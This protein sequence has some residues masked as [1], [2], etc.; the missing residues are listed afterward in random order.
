MLILLNKLGLQNV[1]TN[2]F[3]KWLKFFFFSWKF[4]RHIK[5][6]QFLLLPVSF[7]QI[8]LIVLN[9]IHPFSCLYPNKDPFALI[10]WMFGYVCSIYNLGHQSNKLY[11]LLKL[12]SAFFLGTL[13]NKM[14]TFVMIN[15]LVNSFMLILPSLRP[16]LLFWCLFYFTTSSSVSSYPFLLYR[17]I[18]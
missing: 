10:L 17:N 6:M 7:T 1:R 9:G 18:I 14:G 8:P 13:T 5:A 15:L 3:L 4:W 2:L 16:H 11:C 12:L